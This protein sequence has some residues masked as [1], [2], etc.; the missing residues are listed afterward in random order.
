MKKLNIKKAL[1]ASLASLTLCT[2]LTAVTPAFTASAAAPFI[3]DTD[4][5][6]ALNIDESQIKVSTVNYYNTGAAF[7]TAVSNGVIKS[8]DAKNYLP[9]LDRR[10]VTIRVYGTKCPADVVSKLEKIDL[11]ARFYTDETATS[12]KQ[13]TWRAFKNPQVFSSGKVGSYKCFDLVYEIISYGNRFEFE[14]D[15]IDFMGSLSCAYADMAPLNNGSTYKIYKV[16]SPGEDLLISLRN[17]SSTSYAKVEKWAKRLCV[18]ANSLSQ[19][20]K[21]QRGTVYIAYDVPN[22]GCRSAQT[23]YVNQS[24]AGK[25][26]F[27]STNKSLTN[28][29]LKHIAD[30]K[31]EII[32]G[33]MHEMSH[34]YCITSKTNYNQYFEFIAKNDRWD[35]F[36][37]N[38]RGLTAIQNCDNLRKTDIYYEDDATGVPYSKPYNQIGNCI[39]DSDPRYQFTKKLAVLG[40]KTYGGVSGW[41]KLEQYFAPQSDYQYNSAEVDRVATAMNEYLQ[42]NFS[43]NDTNYLMFANTFRKLYKLTTG[44]SSINTSDIK[45]FNQF[46][47]NSFG[48][49]YLR[50]AET[51]LG[52]N[53]Y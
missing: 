32:W 41:E 52:F 18:L 17:N 47:S 1:S 46:L 42:T 10:K 8:K 37:T 44:K 14:L 9:V 24:D 16:D 31:N 13:G 5:N 12:Y 28:Y 33:M 36:V 2:A 29:D 34:C 4:G 20:T 26:A 49:A 51:H 53:T 40:N 39:T 11:N 50:Q 35:E 3:A 43:L 6:G 22:E 48:K 7:N 27:V 23:G 21:L 19:T 15:K 45:N 30:N 38:A 25:Y